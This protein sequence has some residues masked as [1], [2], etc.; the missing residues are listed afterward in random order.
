MAERPEEPES[1]AQETLEQANPA[2]VAL[3]LAKAR[4]GAKLPPEAADF[5]RRQS[6]LI[7]LQTEHLHEQRELQLAHLRVRRWKDRMSLTL[8]AFGVIVGA[9]LVIGVGVMAW[10]AHEDHG[11]VI[12]AF[13]V[14]PD[15]ARDG[16]TGQVAAGRFLDKLEALQIATS[17]SDRPTQSFQNDWGAQIKVEIPETGLTFGEFEKLLHERLGH[18]SHVAGE[19]LNTPAGIAITARVGDAPPETFAGPRGDFDKLAQQAAES[20]YRQSQPYRF[21]EYLDTHDRSA[22]AVQVISDLAAHGPVSERGWAYASWALM[23]VND[24]GDVA[25]ARLHA[26]KGLGF[27]P[28][29][30]IMD[31]IGVVNTAVWS[32][33]EE[34]DLQVSR[35]IQAETQKR[36]PDTSPLFFSQNRLLG[37]A[38]LQFIQPDYRASA[39]TW[40]QTSTQESRWTDS[41]LSPAM[42]ATAMV[43][44]HD[45]QS[46]RNIMRAASVNDEILL[47]PRIA[48]GAFPALPIYWTAVENGDWAAA[49][50][51]VRRVDA[52]LEAGKVR[53]PIYSLMQQVWIWPLEALALAR[54]G[55]LQAA[56]A[57]IGRTAEDCY[58]CLQVRGQIAAEARDWP[59]AERWFAEAARQGP[60]VPFAYT[61]WGRMLL[62]RGDAKDA[63]AKLALAHAKGPRFA[64]PL[65]FWGEALIQTGD[66]EGAIGKFR[67]ANA[68]APQW[69]RNHLKWGE[70]LAGLGRRGEA[71]VQFQT[72][73]GLDLSAADRAVLDA[74]LAKPG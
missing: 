12:D 14:P 61:D 36:Q 23:D 51:D 39:A 32:G 40:L 49:L 55:D 2:A 22:E 46:A 60:S 30:D 37:T 56:Q 19:V 73:R 64:D 28:G 20:V 72:A 48:T 52:W 68:Y 27:T 71:R 35:L 57:L 65:E 62:L 29:S 15:L 4:A 31:R 33:D 25:A 59:A 63:I 7:D 53:K 69:G 47:M 16:L 70:A 8:Q 11:L 26:S 18:L 3:A 24:R 34:T 13:S 66:F 54:S 67:E 45:L 6:R 5:L 1:E 58:P 9:V 42:A 74:E 21:A 41:S 44:A 50:A 43:K 38:W 17:G 10:Q